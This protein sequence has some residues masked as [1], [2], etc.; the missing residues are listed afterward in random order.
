M[1]IYQPTLIDSPGPFPPSATSDFAPTAHGTRPA[2]QPSRFSDASN[3]FVCSAWHSSPSGWRTRTLPTSAFSF[4]LRHLGCNDRI[5][6]GRKVDNQHRVEGRMA[7]GA[8]RCVDVERS[9]KAP[10]PMALVNVPEDV[11]PRAYAPCRGKE[12]LAADIPAPCAPVEHAMGRA[13]GDQDI[14]VRRNQV[15]LLAK[16]CAAL[17]VEGH[18]KEP[19]L[20]GRAHPAAAMFPPA[21]FVRPRRQAGPPPLRAGPLAVVKHALLTPR[22]PARSMGYRADRHRTR[23]PIN[24][25]ASVCVPSSTIS[26]ATQPPHAPDWYRHGEGCAGPM[27]RLSA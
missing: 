22:N 1:P 27:E 12:F 17:K 6:A 8:I 4:P 13:M 16:L 3:T 5:A 25:S 10:P 20:P 7:A 11:K 2:R 24:S 9:P 19:W 15:P 18:V 21:A 23:A 14:D 26:A